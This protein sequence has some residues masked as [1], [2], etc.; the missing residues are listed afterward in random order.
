MTR[1]TH[2]KKEV[3]DALAYAESV[4]WREGRRQGARVGK[5]VLSVQRLRVPVR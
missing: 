3:E 4:G 2:S 5:N 1:G